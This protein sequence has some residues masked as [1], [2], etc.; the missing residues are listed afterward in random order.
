MY[1]HVWRFCV[2]AGVTNGLVWLWFHHPVMTTL[3]LPAAAAYVLLL[4]RV[5]HMTFNSGSRGPTKP[6]PP[7]RTIWLATLAGFGVVGLMHLEAVVGFTAPVVATLTSPWA[8]SRWLTE[9]RRS[10]RG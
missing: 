3:G 5:W 7:L 8:I 10:T 9:G 1:S 4:A 2:V 6:R